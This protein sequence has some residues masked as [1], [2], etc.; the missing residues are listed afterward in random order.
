MVNSF[1]NFFF[2][3]RVYKMM[4]KV[5]L[6]MT[7]LI[8]TMA[9]I[10][11]KSYFISPT[12]RDPSNGDPSNGWLS[13]AKYDANN[14]MITLMNVSVVVPTNP[15]RTGGQPALWYGLQT[16]NSDG[17]LLQPILKWL[18]RGWYIFHE[19]FDWNNQRDYQSSQFEVKQ[20]DTITQGLSYKKSDNSYD[21]YLH[22]KDTGHT[23]NWNYK[24]RSEQGNTPETVA[25]IVAEHQPSNCAQYPA[26][27]S[28]TFSNIYIEV[29]GQAVTPEW[30][31]HQQRP[32]CDSKAVVVDSKTVKLEWKP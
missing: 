29:E 15:T 31:A 21:F 1:Y 28:I 2:F 4:L 5:I 7:S 16:P 12:E 26:S 11:N 27:G 24:L 3:R 17:A 30:V 22:S 10:A 6:L 19:V 9:N 8:G 25:Y 18:G 20:G 32:A 14:K 23:I 13:Y